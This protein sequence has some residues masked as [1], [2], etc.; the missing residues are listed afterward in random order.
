MPL[1]VTEKAYFVGGDIPALGQELQDDWRRIC[2]KH[3]ELRDLFDHLGLELL[4]R[5]DW[6]PMGWQA[7]DRAAPIPNLTGTGLRHHKTFSK[8]VGRRAFAPDRR[9]KAGKALLKDMVVDGGLMDRHA[10]NRRVLRDA[11]GVQREW[12]FHSVGLR[13]LGDAWVLTVPLKLDGSM[14]Q[15]NNAF[16]FGERIKA[17][18]YVA[19][20]EAAEAV[21]EDV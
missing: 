13:R 11:W 19:M 1:D 9:S 17:S 8:R 7:K 3:D 2:A 4:V 14:P 15:V 20:L 5:N 16:D 12:S 10:V 18:E 21:E 6:E